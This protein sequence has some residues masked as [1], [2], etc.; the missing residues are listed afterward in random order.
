MSAGVFTG[1]LGHSLAIGLPAGALGV[2]AGY[3]LG[4]F[5]GVWLQY[6]GLMA[7]LL[8]FLAGLAVLG[9]FCVDIVLLFGSLF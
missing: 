2:S 4:I 3:L 7:A 9:L 6:L 5:A 1:A 8:N